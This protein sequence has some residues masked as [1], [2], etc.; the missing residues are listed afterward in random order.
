MASLT[1]EGSSL[2]YRSR[3]DSGLVT[4]LKQ[5]I[6]D[7]DRR[8]DKARNA[9]LVAPQYGAV[10]AAITQQ[11]LGETVTAPG[12]K[13]IP[14]RPEQRLLDV[15]YIGTCKDRGSECTAYG[16]SNGSWSVVFPE[17]TLRAWFE[18]EQQPDEATTLYTMLGVAKAATPDELK[19]AYRRLARQWHPDVSKEPGSAEMFKKINAAYQVLSDPPKRAKYDAGLALEASL[20]SSRERR[21]SFLPRTDGYRSPLRCGYVLATGHD[22]LGRFVIDKIEMWDDVVRG[23]GKVLVTSWPMGAETFVEDWL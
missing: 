19:S 3:Y 20:K 16:W 22:S 11:Y 17:K 1:L 7:T 6:P 15:R 5:C 10:L 9:W 21:P 18:Q 14:T 8:W 12:S 13:N 23:D 2:V 4:A